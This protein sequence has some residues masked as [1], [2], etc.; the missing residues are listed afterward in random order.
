MKKILSLLGILSIVLMFNACSEKE[1]TLFDFGGQDFWSFRSAKQSF[2]ADAT[3]KV[4]VYLH[5]LTSSSISPIDVIVE[6]GDGSEGLF[7]VG[8]T[9]F[10]SVDEN[11][12][13]TIE[14]TYSMEDLEFNV[15]YTLELSLSDQPDYP[16][17]GGLITT[18]TVTIVR[19]LTFSSIG[20]GTWTDGIIIALF[21]APT[22]TY[23]VEVEKADQV[24]GIYRLVNPYG[25][26]VYEFTEEGDVIYEPVYVTID[27]TDPDRVI[28]PRAGLGIDWGYGEFFIGSLDYGYGTL[29]GNTITFPAESLGVGMRDWSGD[30][31]G[32]YSEECILVL[33]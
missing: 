12:R 15:P 9:S 30:E 4:N 8:P 17:E 7:S 19:P 23:P 28:I 18:V 29:E 32:V 31:Y 14:I 20:E 22:L 27:A 25:Y 33:P 2:E 5:H 26:G 6:F 10:N 3:G 11:N 21:E 16:R 24:E 1:G 13:A